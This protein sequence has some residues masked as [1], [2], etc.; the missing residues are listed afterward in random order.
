MLRSRLFALC[1]SAAALA[2][3][4]APA[5]H[6]SPADTAYALSNGQVVAFDPASPADSATT[7]AIHGVS[8]GETLVALAVRPQNG[9]IYGLGIDAAADT[10]TLYLIGQDADGA[11]GAWW[12]ALPVGAVGSI[13]LTTD[14]ATAVDLPASGYGLSFNPAVDRAR[15]TTTSGL[16]FRIN[17]STGSPVD[18]DNGGSAGSVT[19]VNADGSLHGASTTAGGVGYTNAAIGAATT[20]AYT[21]DATTDELA[22]LNP[23]NAGTQGSALP[24]THHG[25]PFDAASVS[26]FALDPDAHSDASNTPARS[27]RAYAALKLGSTTKLY[28]I[29]L[30]SGEVTE[31]GT[32]GDGTAP[33]QSL[34]L[35][36]SADADG[37]PAIG[38]DGTGTLRRFETARPA[39]QTTVAITGLAAGEQLVGV[40]WQT[41]TGE[42]IGLGIDAAADTGTVYRIDP[43][44][45]A[46]TA[47]GTPGSV[48]WVGAGGTAVDLP[49]GG[50][51]E[52]F[53]PAYD[54]LRIVNADGLNAR[55][56]PTTGAPIDG[57]LGG[58]GGSVAG[59]N[60]DHPWFDE[61]AGATGP[62]SFTYAYPW[63]HLAGFGPFD[64]G[65]ALEPGSNSV[66]QAVGTRFGRFGDSDAHAVRLADGTALDFG[67]ATAADIPWGKASGAT[68]LMVSSLV[69]GGTPGLYGIN[70]NTGV[71]RTLGTLLSALSALAVGAAE[72][73]RPVSRTDDSPQP[74]TGG[75]DD[76]R[77]VVGSTTPTPYVAPLKPVLPIRTPQ[78]GDHT[79]PVLKGLKV[80]ASTR[81]RLT[82]SFTAS[83]AGKATIKL[84]RTVKHGRKT[85]RKTYRS[86]A[87]TINKAGR[88]TVTF[89][90]LEAG[91]RLR[92]EVTLKDN[93][94]NAARTALKN[95]TVRR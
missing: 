37:Y 22:I 10:G 44:S 60:P 29:D 80:S 87:K 2:A 3:A 73:S 18:G 86:V 32:I 95:A 7:V 50:W 78:P 66:M 6:A 72:P 17:P 47:I 89:K 16:N 75:G 27:G 33:I 46:A 79:A 51:G 69:V 76:T 13:A 4:A 68:G 59:T 9:V 19:G 54:V 39:D 11:P 41:Q 28:E 45:G 58:A 77:S 34:V 48:A 20:T 56:S 74:R 12:T 53:A 36:R 24:L 15:V 1:A 31:V 84:T 65:F 8:S 81:R 91:L 21:I 52:D 71:T 92:V 64:I 30:I 40:S 23:A 42:L 25:V 49:A 82:V 70:P 94:G 35:P 26:G 90:G 43:Q 61:P 93:A 85:V 63:P 62:T 5:A 83:E 88:V 55:V 67:P 14:G 57:D 38:L